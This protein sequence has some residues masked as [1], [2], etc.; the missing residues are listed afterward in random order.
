MIKSN[1][2]VPSNTIRWLALQ[3]PLFIDTIDSVVLFWLSTNTPHW[4]SC[5]ATL[6]THSSAFGLLCTV[7]CI[8]FKWFTSSVMTKFRIRN[9]FSL[10]GDDD[11]DVIAAAKHTAKNPFPLPNSNTFNVP[12]RWLKLHKLVIA[13]SVLKYW[14]IANPVL[15]NPP[16]I[17]VCQ[18]SWKY[19]GMSR[20]YRNGGVPAMVGMFTSVTVQVHRNSSA[21]ESS[22]SCSNPFVSISMLL[23]TSDIWS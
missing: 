2:V 8:I 22:T 19:M 13:D 5:I 16:P 12:H 7:V 6:S 3:L 14:P 4:C 17:P 23:D 11:I 20:T 21:F 1:L 9:L 15:H 18:S 10:F